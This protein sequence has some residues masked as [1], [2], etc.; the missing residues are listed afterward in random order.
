MTRFKSENFHPK[1]VMRV[2]LLPLKTDQLSEDLLSAAFN[3]TLVKEAI[4]LASPVLYA[5]LERLYSNRI[6][7]KKTKERLILSFAKYYSRM[8]SRCT[9]YGLFAACSTGTFGYIN[10]ILFESQN[11]ERQTR[12]DMNFLYALSQKLATKHLK[13][14]LLFFPNNSIY[15]IG[16]QI[17][18]IEYNY[19]GNKRLYQI[20]S[21]NASGHLQTILE[22]ASTGLTM[23]ELATTIMDADIDNATAL[24]FVGELI[25]AQLLV[26]ELEPA[27]T[28]ELFTTQLIKKLVRINSTLKDS[29][30]EMYISSLSDLQKQLNHCD[31]AVFNDP[32]IYRTIFKSL[33]ELSGPIEENQLFQTD[34]YFNPLNATLNE[35]VKAS[36][37]EG[38]NALNKI[39]QG[40][41][42]PHLKK[43]KD[44]FVQHYEDLEMPLLQVLDKETGIGYLTRDTSGYSA[45]ID[46]IALPATP[47]APSVNSKLSKNHALIL[48]KYMEAH[49]TGASVITITEDDLEVLDKEEDVALPL[50]LA[51][52]FKVLNKEGKLLIQ[53]C[54][55]ASASY[56]LGRFA[57][58]SKDIHSTI[59][60]II[61]FEK[62]QFPDKIFAQIIHMPESRIGNI[63]LR[64]VFGEFEIPYLSPSSLPTENQIELK[65]LFVSVRNNKIIL[66]SK[67]LNKEIIPRLGTA[68]NYSFDALPVYQFL[69]DM[70]TQ[71]F[72]KKYLTFDWGI[73][74]SLTPFLPRI[75]YKDCVLWPARWSFT[76]S[77]LQKAANEGIDGLGDFRKRNKLPPRVVIAESDNE[78]LIDFDNDL[79]CRVFLSL[80]RKKPQMILYEF[81]FDNDNALACDTNGGSY[82]N[83][84]IATL[85]NPIHVR[86]PGSL[87]PIENLPEVTRSFSLGSE[88]LYYKIYCGIRSADLLLTEVIR[89]LTLKFQKEGLIDQWFFIRYTD[90]DHHLRLRLH[91]STPAKLAELIFELH[92]ALKIHQT[93]GVIQKIQTDTYKRELERYGYR[94]IT[95]AEAFFHTDS[96]TTLDLLTLLDEIS[97][98]KIKWQ[99]SVKSI[100]SLL[101]DFQLTLQSKCD[102]MDM[103]KTN[104]N[105]EH[106]DTKDLKI[107]LDNKYRR[108][109]KDI[110]DI[111]RGG[112]QDIPGLSTLTLLLAKK[113][114]RVRSVIQ[115][116]LKAIKE[117]DFPVPSYQL[118]AS[119]IHMMLNRIFTA[120]QRTHEMV[121]YNLL[122]KH[123]KS[124][125]AK[126]KPVA[127]VL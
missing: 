35:K 103:L 68:H 85:F 94:Y 118:L 75:E 14:H 98:E 101:N 120:R 127:A 90:P 41:E 113:S 126:E 47:G 57:H 76:Y 38:I 93:S 30:I 111:L 15:R 114:T 53:S 91:T 96:E 112:E 97:G 86:R 117:N 11:I 89:P 77:E 22:K 121:V 106:G 48:K 119:Y 44:S 10:K 72:D 2:P 51:V 27:V 54:G 56:L 23:H 37:L 46:D 108:L 105:K 45:L 6:S 107:Q 5:E 12:P 69:G 74:A 82:V 115:P 20:A 7:D 13:P 80:A 95:T 66:R 87:Q 110:E 125:I 33:N 16:D 83:E 109:R 9:P 40:G 25:E 8:Q 26:S 36:L 67:K 24:D 92:E 29:D 84:C 31:K 49:R 1:F 65:D 32:V 73:V 116:I 28:G 52:M 70:Q 78:L 124:Q 59:N 122:H 58:G 60:D 55:G 81:L 63:I 104:F 21:V 79:S 42:N 50:T 100:E 62:E 4:Y 61:A 43:F 3:D 88:W 102:L 17:R 39:T 34:T 64:P 123:Y 71:Y 19:H 18:Y 99:F